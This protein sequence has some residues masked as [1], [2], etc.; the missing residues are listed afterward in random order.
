MKSKTDLELIHNE[1]LQTVRNRITQ[2]YVVNSDNR[3]F[4]NLE[5]LTV[6]DV[7]TLLHKAPQTIRNWVA[8]RKIPFI[9][10]RPVMFRRK[11]L[12]AWLEKK[13]HKSWQ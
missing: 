1:A 9:P 6:C 5:L 4:E 10:G 13:E 8:Q 12:E 3:L 11:S 2:Q 7:A